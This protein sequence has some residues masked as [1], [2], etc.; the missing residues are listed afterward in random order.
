MSNM[1]KSVKELADHLPQWM[2]TDKDRVIYSAL[3]SLFEETGEICGC[4]SKYRIRKNYNQKP[5]MLDNY[6][7]IR[8][9][10]MDEAGDLLWVLICSI[11]RLAPETVDFTKIFN[12][13][14]TYN[15]SLE[16]AIFDFAEIL[17]CLRNDLQGNDVHLNDTFI[18]LVYAY[19]TFVQAL[20]L[21]YEITLEEV[22]EYNMNKLNARYTSDGVRTDG[23]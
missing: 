14:R 20:F 5:N 16:D 4:I 9:K 13:P 7:D 6:K 18:D 12:D 8:I 21:E 3:S 19:K 11:Q 22:V 2:S 15:M 1:E 10:F 17:V 23:K